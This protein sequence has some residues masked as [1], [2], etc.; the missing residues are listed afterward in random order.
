M[1]SL[2]EYW[3][4]Q[5]LFAWLLLP[6]SWIY[7]VLA[8]SRRFLY[9]K[10]L[11]KSYSVSVPLIVIGNIS[12]GG[13]GKTP[14]LIA[15]CE[16]L[17]KQGLQPGIVSRG[18]GGSFSG[19]QLVSENDTAEHVGDEPFL[20]A[21]R[22]QCPVAVGNDRVAAA[23]LLLRHHSCDVILSDDGL[24]HYRMQRDFEIAVV[25]VNRQLGNGFCL[26]AG[27]LREPAGRLQSVDMV[28]HHGRSANAN[29]FVLEFMDAVN[30]VTGETRP[31]ESF[32]DSAVH[33]IAGIGH[34]E[35]FFEQLAQAGLRIIKHPFPDHYAYKKSDLVFDDNDNDKVLLMTEKDAVKCKAY[36]VGN[37]WYVPVAARLSDGLISHVT[38]KI[39]GMADA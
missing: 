26:P 17:V 33:A 15:L 34:P 10:R 28:V 13:T 22:T 19:E 4:N 32:K 29:S 1:R 24:Q 35:R 7:C 37:C 27:P 11:L 14:L 6:V 23:E 2:D 38:G 36:T 9:K 30:L 5:N 12:V 20:M 39:K 3:Y 31:I 21:Q 18:Y 8:L 16:L 25:D